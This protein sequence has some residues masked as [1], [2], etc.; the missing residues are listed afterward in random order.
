M[1]SGINTIFEFISEKALLTQFY[2]E[3]PYDKFSS[4]GDSGF[5]SFT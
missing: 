1:F 2:R 4:T 5:I 3:D